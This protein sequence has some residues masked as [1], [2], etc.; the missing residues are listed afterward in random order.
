VLNG[1]TSGRI[2][3]MEGAKVT[4]VAAALSG[5]AV[6]TTMS[7]A[8]QERPQFDAESR[9]SLIIGRDVFE[10]QYRL[11]LAEGAN[12]AIDDQDATAIGT[13]Y[14]GISGI[15][16]GGVKLSVD[17]RTNPRRRTLELPLFVKGYVAGRY[18]IRVSGTS[19]LEPGTELILADKYLNTR[20]VLHEDQVYEFELNPAIAESFGVGRFM[21]IIKPQV[22]GQQPEADVAVEASEIL[23]YPNPFVSSFRL[24]V[25][26][27]VPFRMELRL[28]DLMGQ[29]KLRRSFGPVNGMDAMEVDTNALASGIYFMEL[30]NLDTGSTIKTSKLIKR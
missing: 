17:T 29:L 26:A 13:G 1:Q 10:Q 16:S 5:I 30:I 2:R 28:R 12:D 3:F 7:L 19:T 9:I 25:P 14:V 24:K 8:P 23:A 27:A 6:R 11:V 18:K 21:L 20:Q 22:S 4:S 15:G